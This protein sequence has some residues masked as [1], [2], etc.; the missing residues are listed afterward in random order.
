MSKESRNEIIGR[1]DQNIVRYPKILEDNFGQDTNL[2]FSVLSFIMTKFKSNLFNSVTFTI[3]E[4]CDKYGYHK[5]NI[6]SRHSMFKELNEEALKGRP[7]KNE[8]RP[9]QSDNHI[10]W[11]EIDHV[12]YRMMKEN[13]VF[14]EEQAPNAK[15]LSSVRSLQLLRSVKIRNAKTR[16]GKEEHVY[17]VTLGSE[18]LLNSLRWYVSYKERSFIE[19]GKNKNGLGKRGVYMY[20]LSQYQR[21]LLSHFPQ[22]EVNP[23]F[24]MLCSLAR[25]NN[26][27]KRNNKEKLI[28][29]LDSVGRPEHLDFTHNLRSVDLDDPNF[30]IIVTFNTVEFYEKKSYADFFDEL[31]TLIGK[32][33]ES[34]YYDKTKPK[35]EKYYENFQLWCNTEV[36]MEEKAEIVVQVFKKNFKVS[37][38]H[39][40]ALA[41]ISRPENW[42][43][44][45]SQL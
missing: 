16:S 13:I 32:L 44:L 43:V 2:A 28:K 37:V 41:A 27:Q 39:E 25:L 9:Y 35:D 3:S 4:F 30:K 33:Y 38:T 15:Y 1:I 8:S 12:L 20:F 34:L 36:N 42:H 21:C 23:N 5:N 24:D 19:L 7:K 10:W 11:S 29:I 22:K 40:Q 18:I 6:C 45:L 31:L 17:E 26:A 14:N